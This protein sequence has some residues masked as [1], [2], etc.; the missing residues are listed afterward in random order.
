MTARGGKPQA[1]QGALRT[2]ARGCAIT[3]GAAEQFAAEIDGCPAL[4][5]DK[6][7]L[8]LDQQK[9][10][11]L[12]RFLLFLFSDFSRRGSNDAFFLQSAKSGSANIQ[13]DFFTVDDEGAL[14]DIRLEDFAGV[15]LGE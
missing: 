4:G 3:A 14:R 10:P 13:A 11:R 2:P 7:R 12:G 9:T 1:L 5:A 15:A 8:T 6:I